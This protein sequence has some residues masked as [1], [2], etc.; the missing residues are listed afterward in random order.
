V[1]D[2][3]QTWEELE[4]EAFRIQEEQARKNNRNFIGFAWQGD[5]YEGL[6]CNALE[7]VASSDAVKENGTIDYDSEAFFNAISRARG[8]VKGQNGHDPISAPALGF[9]EKESLDAFKDGKA[10]FLRSW[11]SKYVE[12]K[13]EM[14]DKL[15]VAR[16]PRNVGVLGGVALV[17]PQSSKNKVDALRF[18][19]YIRSEEVRQW[20]A[21]AAG[22]GPP[23]SELNGILSKTKAIIRPSDEA[24]YVK[25]SKCFSQAIK[26][27]ID[28]EGD[29]QEKVKAIAQCRLTKVTLQLTGRP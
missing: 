20:R 22:G 10:A 12:L 15:G 2:P 13:N 25:K 4:Q 11:P 23:P 5:A 29:F 19:E 21:R 28:T 8:W 6:T 3:P 16:L 18:I 27:A 17:V 9:K 26:N 1:G 7:W 24:D 14:K